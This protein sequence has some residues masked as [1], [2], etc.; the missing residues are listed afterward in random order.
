LAA[1][2]LG[3]SLVGA[4]GAP[5]IQVAD[6]S[7]VIPLNGSDDF[8]TT[9]V[10]VP[11]SKTFTVTNPPSATANLVVSEAITVPQGFTLM[12]N[13]PGAPDVYNS[14]GGYPGFTV[15]PGA[16][17]TFT[18]ALNS[19][20]AGNFSGNVSFNTGVPG[21]D[22][23]VFQVT[24]KVLPPPSVRYIDDIDPGFAFTSGWTPGYTAAGISGQV[25]FQGS[26]TY[27]PAGTG[28]ETAT[29]T[30]PGLEPGPYQ[31]SA[32]WVSYGGA[33]NAPFTVLDGTTPV[34][35][36]LVDQT[37][38]AAGFTDGGSAWQNLGTFT[39][40]G[41]TLAV[42]LTDNANNFVIADGVRIQ[43]LGYDGQIV[44]DAG[45]GFSTTGTWT[46]NPTGPGVAFQTSYT[47]ASPTSTPGTPTATAQWAFTVTA[48]TYRV[49][50]GFKGYSG[51]A[52]NAPFSVL[53]NNTLLTPAPI[54]VDQT[55]TPTDIS[56]D[57][58][59]WK[60]LG[61]F[62]VS[63]AT[64]K[65]QLTN[66][67]NNSVSADA[68]R[69]ERVNTPTTR[70]MA[71]TVRFLEQASWGPTPAL[72]TAVQGMGFEAWINQQFTVAAT[73]YPTLPLYSTNTN[74]T[75]NNTVSCYGDPTVSGN[76]ARTACLRD[77][78]Q[79]NGTGLYPLQTQ[80]FTNALYG[81]DQL[82]QRTAWALHKIWV[83][84]SAELTQSA[85]MAP[86]LQIL[87]NDAFGNYRFLMYDVTLNPAMGKYLSMAGSTKTNPNENYAREIMQL[88]TIGL[89]ELNPNGSQKLDG[90]GQ[91]I[92]T[93]DQNLVD[94]M[95]KVFTGWNFA[96]NTLPGQS[97][98]STGGNT[99]TTLND[100]NQNWVTN[101]WAGL[102]VSI[103]GGGLANQSRT[104]LS[105][106]ATQLTVTTAW[107]GTPTTPNYTIN[108][109]SILNYIDAMRLGGAATENPANHDFTAKPLL[110]NYVQPARTPTTGTAGI[111]NAYADLNEA[112]DLLF[113][114]PCTAPFVCQQLIQQLVTS[115]PSPG[116]V[117]RVADTFQRNAQNPTQMQEVVKAIL[118]DPEA[119]GDRK[120][121]PNYGKLR[122]PVLFMNNL[123]RMFDAK[124][125]DRTQNSDGYLVYGNYYSMVQGQEVYNPPSVF[126][127]F[128]PA[129]VA[130]G[131]PPPLLGP[132]FQ[133][134]TTTTTLARINFVNQAFTPNSTR[135]VDV[136]RTHGTT[137]SGT[138]PVTGQPLVPTGPFGT[139]VNID[140]PAPGGN[141]LLS[142]F[143]DP[144]GLTEQ[145]NQLMMHG[146]MTP[147]MKSNIVTAVTAVTL[148]STP[149]DAQK[150]KRVHTAIYLVATSSQYQVQR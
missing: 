93:Y 70:S 150:R 111:N 45:P 140:I 66:D 143:N 149:T 8:G 110:R 30:F 121:D 146:T 128:S 22:P 90:T 74:L 16:S 142:Y 54:R 63:S 39:I 1:A 144:A 122:E 24:G 108:T 59:G 102:T 85:W 88:F 79:S 71:D 28:T 82:R 137:P 133:I 141:T 32:T 3:A 43:R 6:G 95:T 148:S 62:T 40:T 115:N 81:Q 2:V 101:Q 132:E 91:P 89:F 105:N 48:G 56:D 36:V 29:W 106:T 34:G 87:S 61:F 72:I 17:V 126:S 25:P 109:S 76:P 33:S 123:L 119:R 68:V 120:N 20:T 11:L 77:H 127:Y 98:T 94:N 135:A 4:P 139:A 27:A 112:L 136:V 23:F 117:A 83:V 84:S 44:D 116:Y 42:T 113:Y 37:V 47:S 14:T 92:A 12:A 67:A 35:T 130:V 18:V 10:G 57:A 51:A 19:R 13:F 21:K 125:D 114:H 86:Y 5:D 65:V 118:L 49:L 100:T 147:E 60:D 55:V 145:L 134:F 46:A 69:I 50:A 124:S 96:P 138:D 9:P 104:I 64:L 103:T 58:V 53:D 41:S 75:N 78:Y 131:G 31:V 15:T 73:S 97:G 80:F 129:K 52:T 99:T 107:T 7:T 38:D 26:V